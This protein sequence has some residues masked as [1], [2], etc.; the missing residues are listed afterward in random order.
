[1]EF[2][3]RDD[4]RV[5]VGYEEGEPTVIVGVPHDKA[6]VMSLTMF[7]HC[8]GIVD[9]ECAKLNIAIHEAADASLQ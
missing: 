4:V 9:A 6:I 1:M 2:D 3:H 5:I 7:M 8:V